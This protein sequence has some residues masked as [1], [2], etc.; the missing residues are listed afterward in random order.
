MTMKQDSRG[1]GW[2][3]AAGNNLIKWRVYKWAAS[4][5]SIRA[6]ASL[7]TKL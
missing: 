4:A 2:A 6:S 3:V 5:A 1:S 7:N